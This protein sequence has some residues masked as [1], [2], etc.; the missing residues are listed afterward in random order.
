MFLLLIFEMCLVVSTKFFNSCSLSYC[1]SAYLF[2][3]DEFVSSAQVTGVSLS[4]V[5]EV[6][7]SHSL[8]RI[9]ELFLPLA[10]PDR[11]SYSQVLA[12]SVTV[13]GFTRNP[14]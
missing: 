9:R 2:W 1:T 13:A 8:S 6:L 14:V 3:A 5:F 7:A 11:L 10:P 12:A 4:C